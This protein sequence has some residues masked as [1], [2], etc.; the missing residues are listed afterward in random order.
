ML[1]YMADDDDDDDIP[2]YKTRP[3]GHVMNNVHLSTLNDLLHANIFYMRPLKSRLSIARG[4]CSS[5][6]NDIWRAHRRLDTK[7]FFI[8]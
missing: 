2:I 5:V 3:L 1:L 7:F 8:F 6:E 4:F